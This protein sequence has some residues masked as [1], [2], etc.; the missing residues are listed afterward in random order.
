MIK[1]FL[2]NKIDL[3]KW[4][5]CI[6]QSL[7]GIVYAKSYY[8]NNM[9]PDWNALILGDYEAVMP[10]TWRKKWQIKYL[11]QPAF[12]QQLGLR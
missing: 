10:V 8:L 11:A 12:T 5:S 7:N 9:S 2:H 1:Y 3:V 4:D 6:D